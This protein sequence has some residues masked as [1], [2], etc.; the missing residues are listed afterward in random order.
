MLFN[1]IIITNKKW[2][3][4]KNLYCYLKAVLSTIAFGWYFL[5]ST[6]NIMNIFLLCILSWWYYHYGVV[7]IEDHRRNVISFITSGIF[8]CALILGRFGLTERTMLE[9]LSKYSQGIIKDAPIIY[10]SLIAEPGF[11]YF[12]LLVS[13][14]GIWVFLYYFFFHVIGF[15]HSNK[16]SQMFIKSQENTYSSKKIFI[17][18]FCVIIACWIPYFLICYPGI[19]TYDSINQISQIEGDLKLNNV[20]SIANILL[21]SIFYKLGQFIWKSKNAGIATW[22]FIQMCLLASIYAHTIKILYKYGL[23]KKICFMILVF[24]A[25]IPLNAMY[26]ITQWKDILF[27]GFVLWFSVS[28]YRIFVHNENSLYA[29]LA[30]IISA[31][32]MILFRNNGIYAYCFFIV[33]LFLIKKTNLFKYKN[34]VLLPLLAIL[35]GPVFKSN[36]II[37]HNNLDPY[38]MLIQQI[39]RVAVEHEGQLEADDIIRIE[40]LAPIE[41]IQANYNSRLADPIKI[42]LAKSGGDIFIVENK[43]EFLGDWLNLARKYPLTYAQAIIDATVGYWYPDLQYATIFIGVEPNNYGITSANSNTLLNDIYKWS[44]LYRVIPILG[45]CFSIGSAFL[46]MVFIMFIQIY[47]RQY[48]ELL[49]SIPVWGIWGTVILTAPLYAEMRYIY[50]ML[51]VT[52]FVIGVFIT[53][54]FFNKK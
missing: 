54:N 29:Y 49:V 51:I 35:A 26:S 11:G 25:C 18:S 43:K 27:S 46:I 21:I 45:S 47:E 42:T 28:V 7:H 20:H 36:D 3:L 32:G 23:K 5:Y 38:C 14:I 48:S 16:L 52:P 22:I 33:S 41:E 2:N 6:G 44:N 12:M 31:I 17:L 4:N 13:I 8:S 40:K 37:L 10:S 24:F 39:S 53:S 15:L 50:S 1:H 34:I 19:L 30:F 9:E